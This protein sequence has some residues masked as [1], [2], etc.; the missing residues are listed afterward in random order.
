M[1]IPNLRN[2]PPWVRWLFETADNPL[3]DYILVTPIASIQ[4]SWWYQKECSIKTFDDLEEKD[5]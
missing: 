3:D 5:K 4:L 1:E 2:E